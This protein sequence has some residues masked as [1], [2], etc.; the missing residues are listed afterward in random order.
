MLRFTLQNFPFES[1]YESV[2]EKGTTPI[3]PI[4]DDKMDHILELLYS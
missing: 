4:S 3:K 2:T 1:N